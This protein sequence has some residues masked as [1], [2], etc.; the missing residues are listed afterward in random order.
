MGGS[1]CLDAM[2]HACSHT[3]PYPNVATDGCEVWCR[4]VI[5]K[6]AG[7]VFLGVLT[8]MTPMCTLPGV[9][10]VVAD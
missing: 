7:S 6:S 4:A 10:A 9:R 1:A 5:C 8:H 2:Q 3:N